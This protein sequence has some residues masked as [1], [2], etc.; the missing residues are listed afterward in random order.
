MFDTFSTFYIHIDTLF[1]FWFKIHCALSNLHLQS[2][3]ICLDNIFDS[4]IFVIILNPLT[5]M[6]VILFVLFY[7]FVLFHVFTDES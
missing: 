3:E 1:H 7:C 6:T 5:F 2:H 4:F